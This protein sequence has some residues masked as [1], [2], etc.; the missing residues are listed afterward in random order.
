MGVRWGMGNGQG[1]GY[2][3]T[4][5]LEKK[6]VTLREVDTKKWWVWVQ[7]CEIQKDIKSCRERR[8]GRKEV[9]KRREGGMEGR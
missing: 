3:L 5:Y 6:E 1:E 4:I 8:Y 2:S 7:G 9:G